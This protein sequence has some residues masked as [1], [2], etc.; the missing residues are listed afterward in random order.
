MMEA[1]CGGFVGCGRALSFFLSE[2]EPRKNSEQRR[3]VPNSGVHR[4]LLHVGTGGGREH[5]KKEATMIQV[6]AEEGGQ[7]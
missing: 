5:R 4:H 1:D 2:M 6:L 3:D 7:D